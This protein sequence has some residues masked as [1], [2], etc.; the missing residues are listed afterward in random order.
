[1]GGRVV[2]IWDGYTTSNGYPY[3]QEMQL[4]DATGIPPGSS[5]LSGIAN[6][7]RNSVKV[8]V[9]AYSGAMRFYVSDPSDPII[10]V[11]MRAFPALFTPMSDAPAS[12]QAHFRYPENLFQ[13]QA[14]Q[15]ANYHVTNP[16]TFYG[17]QDFWSIPPDPAAGAN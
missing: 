8:V 14:T 16:S 2:W 1:V 11:W 6:Y 5:G 17:K 7:V 15:Y 4:S 12:L 13:V 3:S 9:D 10:Q